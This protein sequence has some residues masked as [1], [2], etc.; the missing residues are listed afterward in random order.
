MVCPLLDAR[1]GTCLVYEARPVACRAYGF[2]A[3]REF[4]LGCFRIRA[5]ADELPDVV[6][7][8]HVALEGELRALGEAAELA[9]H[10]G[11]DDADAVD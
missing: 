5:I 7:G 10:I 1:S 2:Y 3:E 8:N 6:W 11:A 9:V 4:V